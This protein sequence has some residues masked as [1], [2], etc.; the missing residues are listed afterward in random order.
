MYS[1]SK[2][3]RFLFFALMFNV[4]GQLLLFSIFNIFNIRLAFIE[5]IIISQVLLVFMPVVIYFLYTKAPIKD[6]LLFNKI[7]LKTIVMCILL[8]YLIMPLI[9]LTN[10]ISQFFV[11]NHII[12]SINSSNDLSIWL[13]LLTLGVF[14]S[15]F[16]E[17]STRAI[18]ISNY[19]NKSWISTCLVSGLFFGILHMNI[20]QFSYAFVIGVIQCFIVLITGSVFSAMIM[21]FVINSST[22][23]LSKLIYLVDVP[24][25]ISS[26]V[27][28][29]QELLYSAI[30]LIVLCAITLPFAVLIITYL[31]KKNSKLSLLNKKTTTYQLFNGEE[32]TDDETSSIAE[33]ITTP[34]F[35]ASI[36]TF[37]IFVT[38]LEFF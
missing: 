16:E 20:N 15:I 36:I 32:I 33:K 23:F 7:D 24:D 29:N 14:P 6:T 31:I 25:D 27:A 26:V 21:H 9:S 1:V 8:T 28:T 3:N 12:D 37:V 4:V 5:S 35:I 30:S 22:I 34:C 19:R 18:L 17:L 13:L 11:K 10:I 38:L 2:G